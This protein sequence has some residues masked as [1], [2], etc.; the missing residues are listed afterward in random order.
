MRTSKKSTPLL[1]KGESV[2]NVVDKTS[3]HIRVALGTAKLISNIRSRYVGRNGER[4]ADLVIRGLWRD[5]C[6]LDALKK[7]STSGGDDAIIT[8]R[9]EDAA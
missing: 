2:K 7:R 6:E 8:G 4:S 5:A 1:R 9:H 3:T